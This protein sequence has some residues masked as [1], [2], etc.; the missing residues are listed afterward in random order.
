MCK[1]RLFWRAC[2]IPHLL[3][4]L[5]YLFAGILN[6]LLSSQEDKDVT[7]WFADMDLHNCPDGC[8]QVVPFR[9]L[10]YHECGLNEHSDMGQDCICRMQAPTDSTCIANR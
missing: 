5:G 8:L 4:F 3:N 6:L 2:L 7:R 10:Q 9:L 1:I